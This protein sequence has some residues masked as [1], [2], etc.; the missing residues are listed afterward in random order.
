MF[1]KVLVAEDLDSINLGIEQALREFDIL[2]FHHS[3]YCDDAF[4]KVRKAISDGEPYDLLISDLSFKKDHREV[5]L[6]SGEELIAKV[7]ALQPETKIIA[8]S[9]E[10]KSN[11]IRFLFDNLRINA[12]VCK[13]RNSIN[14]LKN[15]I[16]LLAQTDETYVSQEMASALTGKK[17]YEIDDIDVLIMKH[18]SLGILQDE[19][20]ETFK[21]SGIKPNSKSSI[22][23]RIARLKDFFKA[24]N[25]AHLVAIAKDMG[26]L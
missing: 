10:D 22:E 4:L 24:K 18:L 8:Y 23:K 3:K 17:K 12:F 15:A 13:G 7:R 20:S 11:H 2:S 26:V 9:V 25:T 1:K 14:E 5:D 6:A 21:G 19:I 16:M